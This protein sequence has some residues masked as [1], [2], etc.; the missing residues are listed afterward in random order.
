MIRISPAFL[1]RLMQIEPGEWIGETSER[2][3]EMYQALQRKLC[4]MHPPF[5]MVESS[6]CKTGED[7][8]FLIRE[9]DAKQMES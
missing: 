5:C 6:R 9:E 7:R 4:D 8:F 1:A 3:Q 2:K